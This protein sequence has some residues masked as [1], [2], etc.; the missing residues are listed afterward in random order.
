M[1]PDK[2]GNAPTTLRTHW[3]QAMYQELTKV[4][5]EASELSSIRQPNCC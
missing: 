4:V 1:I 3:R 5:H 2:V